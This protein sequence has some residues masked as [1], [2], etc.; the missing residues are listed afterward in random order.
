MDVQLISYDT[1][2]TFP[3]PLD[4][5][6]VTFNGSKPSLENDNDNDGILKDYYGPLDL[7]IVPITRLYVTLTGCI[8]KRVR[9]IIH[10]HNVFPYFYVPLPKADTWSDRQLSENLLKWLIEINS[11]MASS[12]RNRKGNKRKKKHRK[13]G[14][15]RKVEDNVKEKDHQ[16]EDD[17]QYED[18]DNDNDD[19]DDD[20]DF[21]TTRSYVANLSIVSGT[22]IYGYHIGRNTF[23]KISMASPKY[24]ARLTRLCTE[25]KIFDRFI[26]PYESH[27]PYILQFL[28]DYNCYA[29]KTIHFTE[30]LWRSPLV[31]IDDMGEEE[32]DDLF[33]PFFKTNFTHYNSLKINDSLVEF[34]NQ[35]IH[36]IPQTT[37]LNILDVDDFPRM[38]RSL[39][40]LD[41]CASW[42]QNRLN[43]TERE[44]DQFDS[45]KLKGDV[46]YITST[47]SLLDDVDNLRRS[48]GL[49]CEK[50]QL[51]LYDHMERNEDPMKW[52]DDEELS[53]FFAKA[54]NLSETSFKRKYK[55]SNIEDVKKLLHFP[56]FQTAFQSI[57]NLQFTP[58]LS[59]E[60]LLSSETLNSDNYFQSLRKMQAGHKSQRPRNIQRIPPIVDVVMPPIPEERISN[61]STGT[62][63]DDDVID[64]DL[65]H[66]LD[67]DDAHVAD[68]ES[69]EAINPNDSH[70]LTDRLQASMLEDDGQNITGNH[71]KLLS[72]LRMD[73]TPA[74]KTISLLKRTDLLSATLT[75]KNA[76]VSYFDDIDAD[77]ETIFT[78]NLQ[79]PVATSK[80]EFLQTFETEFGMPKV[81]Y[82]DPF[83]SELSNYDAKPFIFAGE[84]FQLSCLETDKMLYP[85]GEQIP[86]SERDE[87]DKYIWRYTPPMP[88]YKDVSDWLIKEKENNI[89][90][91]NPLSTFFKTQIKGPT[92]KF[93]EYKYPS[94]QTPTERI[95]ATTN[96]LTL[97][98]V[99][100]Y[101]DTRTE[102]LPDPK[103]D[104]IRAIFWTF[105]NQDSIVP[106]TGAFVNTSGD[107][108][109]VKYIQ[110][111]INETDIFL[112]TYDSELDTLIALVSLMEYI[113]PDIMAGWEL[114]SS[115][116]GYILERA[117]SKYEIDLGVR[118]SRV[119]EKHNNKMGD[120]WGY[121]HASGIKLTG[122]QMLNIWRRFRSELNLN[123][124]SLE[125]VVFH[126]FHE[127]VPHFNHEKL[128]MLW[129]QSQRGMSYVLN[130]YVRRIT[131]EMD[132]ILKLE[133]VEKINEQSRLLG[134]DFY[135]IIY[136]GSQFKVECL[137]VRL[138]KAEN[139]MLISASK[140][141]VF[142][143]DSLECI[144]LV[145]E[146]NS[147]FYKCPL[148]V[149]D[150][151][152]LYPSLII[153]YNICYSTQLGR[154]K[155]YNPSKY[156]KMGVTN[157][158]SPEG[159]LKYL[160]DNVNITP[161]GMMF[162]KSNV[163]K[164]LLARM[165]LEILNAR[166]Y[167]KTTMSEF[168]DDQELKKLYNNR[169]L[170]LKL[171]A[172]VTYGYTSASYSGRMPNSDI[173]DSIVSCARETLLKAVKI[174]EGNPK[175]GATVV[176]GD[177]D[178]LFVYL[179]G[180]T[181]EEAFKLGKEMADHVTYS[182]PAPVKL[183]FEKVY[184]PSILVSKKRYV[185]WSYEYE[186][187]LTPK[188]DAKGIETVRRDGIPAQQKILEKALTILFDTKDITI[189][190]EYLTG[191]FAKVINQKVNI[192]DFMFAKEVRVGTYKNEKYIPAGAR[193]AMKRALDDH[194]LEPQ[195]KERVLYVVRKGHSKEILRD[196][197][198]S[199]SDFIENNM[200]LDSEYYINKVLIPPLERVLNLLGVDV[201][202]W[203]KTIPQSISYKGIDTVLTNV[204]VNSCLACGKTGVK[205]KLCQNCQEN[206]LQTLLT[207]RKR[208]QG[209]EGKSISFFQFCKSCESNVVGELPDASLI[210]ECRNEDCT[211]FYRRTKNLRETEEVMKQLSELPEW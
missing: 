16:T 185:G 84:K 112:T 3:S 125:N 99:E 79:Q 20:V 6:I 142:K 58:K 64:L 141:Q 29:L 15:Q 5:T 198:V 23:L 33:Q 182:N 82:E 160:E 154:L 203:V 19:D 12:Y 209:L 176:Y 40:E 157:Y 32:D 177:T 186:T 211:I 135:S 133:V 89:P 113:D 180:K 204:K 114:H 189:L 96:N 128:T 59:S 69:T 170:A 110:R 65:G 138:A 72:S 24:V 31:H 190:K 51:G 55:S 197:C 48:R 53:K 60:F 9:A 140:R 76:F 98:I 93:K 90:N 122:R 88:S 25:S 56:N 147:A 155:D 156:T 94:L 108:K 17:H 179:P 144:P 45:V 163:R 73:T 143:Q 178:S 46:T 34:I 121:T 111:I 14:K 36:K 47:K 2:Q 165:L 172:N 80:D 10:V 44:V 168:K 137:L 123:H 61:A 127:R 136:R 132:L 104:E 26:Q 134:I 38:G 52:T 77:E 71:S 68:Q 194:R 124:Y 207:L 175:W 87:D 70:N 173:A 152:S 85:Y 167:I 184:L 100:V 199:P 57:Q 67:L 193:M 22:P 139:F 8:D 81:E 166:I 21:S 42:I 181:K 27:I 4:K 200:Q 83:F 11:K 119:I 116:W 78:F 109:H 54:L 188:F 62:S 162:A 91:S 107:W 102:Y 43:L 187:Q 146:P 205:G 126:I 39:F 196:R 106:Q 206:E 101:V 41:V 18:S 105:N 158:K 30:F 120:R 153:A 50:S 210:S 66:D 129:N 169:Q 171:I 208:V 202:S 130:Y 174:I 149:L 37:A 86:F 115:S 192:K 131:Y 117:L 191:E 97:L 95:H 74:F 103:L 13:K 7:D 28:T 164:S 151:Q 75:Q 63:D 183:K 161:N 201:R 159:I 1:Y 148:V 118:F 49:H 145:M 150:F 35:H 195:Y 92:Q